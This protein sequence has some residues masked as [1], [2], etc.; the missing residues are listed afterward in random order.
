[1]LDLSGAT[2]GLSD[3]RS[4]GGGP[5]HAFETVS[6][7]HAPTGPD[8]R[9]LQSDDWACDFCGTHLHIDEVD[10]GFAAR[11]FDHLLKCPLVLQMAV[12]FGHPIWEFAWPEIVTWPD[13]A[14]LL[15]QH[16]IRNVRLWQLNAKISA[17]PAFEYMYLVQCGKW[18]L[19]DSVIRAMLNNAC[20]LCGRT[21]FSA[22]QFL[23]HL[24]ES[25]NFHQ[26]D[27]EHCHNLLVY[28][29]NNEQCDFC[30]T[31]SH[32]QTPGRRCV[33]LFNLAV[34]LCNCHGFYWGR[35]YAG[36]TDRR[37]L[38]TSPQ[39]RCPGTIDQREAGAE[40]RVTGQKAKSQR[41]RQ[42]QGARSGT[43]VAPPDS[44]CHAA[45]GRDQ[46][47]ADGDS[48]FDPLQSGSRIDCG[49]DGPG[50]AHH[51]ATLP[52]P[53]YDE[54]PIRASDQALTGDTDGSD[55]T[56]LSNVSPGRCTGPDA[57][58]SM[59]PNPEEID[60]E[61]GKT[62]QYGGD[63][64]RGEEH[65]APYAGRNH[66]GEISCAEEGGGDPRSN[67]SHGSGPPPQ[68]ECGALERAQEALIPR[69]MATYYGKD[70]ASDHAA[71]SLGA[72]TDEGPA[73]YS[74][75]LLLNQTGTCCFVNATVLGLAWMAMLCHAL[76]PT[77]LAL[78]FSFDGTAHVLE[79][80]AD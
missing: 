58:P 25:H 3:S 34:Y 47:P 71:Q 7:P 8:L 57:L 6:V 75:R 60:P 80:C 76:S 27:S 39:A 78:R 15:E 36:C 5:R 69:F 65:P 19:D 32:A 16:R 20:L 56:G 29:Q 21:F 30:G 53:T 51:P 9:G 64:S 73:K 66:H 50:E 14:T 4:L 49:R 52:G 38:A 1:M 68:G 54:Y 24:F 44:T 37:D 35:Q 74:L 23:K 42:G 72:A 2:A 41:T 46:C 33:A 63:T 79:P 10:F 67:R 48:V 18:Y 28:L 62:D 12:L 77:V 22:W 11:A 13:Q 61:Q 40:G 45:R 70:Q 17:H 31:R 43:A 55:H 26:M 59:V